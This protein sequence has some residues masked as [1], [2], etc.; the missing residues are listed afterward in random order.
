MVFDT[1]SN[2]K[3]C[4]THALF[5]SV[6]SNDLERLIRIFNDTKRRA[7]SMAATALAMSSVS[8]GLI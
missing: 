4:L 7:V 2:C 8:T 6:I 3:G 5:S 1:L